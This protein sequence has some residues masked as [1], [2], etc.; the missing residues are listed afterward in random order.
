MDNGYF[1][2][3]QIIENVNSEMENLNEEGFML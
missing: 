3:W 1:S 2:D